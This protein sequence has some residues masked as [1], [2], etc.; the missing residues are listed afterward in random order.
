MS[1]GEKDRE[2]K[3][4]G[5]DPELASLGE[6]YGGDRDTQDGGLRRPPNQARVRLSTTIRQTGCQKERPLLR[7]VRQTFYHSSC[8]YNQPRL[9]SIVL[10]YLFLLGRAVCVLLI[11]FPFLGRLS[12]NYISK[13]LSS[14]TTLTSPTNP[15]I[16]IMGE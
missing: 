5:D 3:G 6:N 2:S 15:R 8:Y 11:L 1:E 7:Q 9:V 4:V 12:V 10:F 16:E 14:Q 13:P